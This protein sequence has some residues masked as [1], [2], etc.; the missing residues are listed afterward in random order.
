VKAK[1][2]KQATTRAKAMNQ[3]LR[4]SDFAQAFGRAVSPYG[5]ASY[6]TAEAVPLS[7]ASSRGWG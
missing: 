2:A 5:E 6:G 1:K 7:K 4:P 3:S